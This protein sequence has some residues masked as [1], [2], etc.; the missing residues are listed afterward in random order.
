MQDIKDTTDTLTLFS[1][2][3]LCERLNLSERTIENMVSRN[4]FP[5]PVRI[6]KKVYWS[7]QVVAAWKLKVFKRQQDW[8]QRNGF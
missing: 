2:T 5:P 1:K 6:G 7:E 3:D 4:E 8:F